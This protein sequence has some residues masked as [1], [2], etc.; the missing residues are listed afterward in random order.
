MNG[1]FAPARAPRRFAVGLLR[2]LGELIVMPVVVGMASVLVAVGLFPLFGTAGGAVKRFDERLLSHEKTKITLPPLPERSTIY[3]ADGTRLATL[4]LDENREIVSLKQVNDV[5]Q[6][7]VLAIEDHKFFEHGPVDISSILR[8]AIAN[9]KAGHIVQGG[10]TISQQLIKNTETGNAETFQRKF[11]EAQDAILLEKEY[12]KAQILELYLNTIYFGHRVYGIGTAA[13]YYF[14]RSASRLTAAQAALLGGMI[15]SPVTFD[16]IEHPDTALIRRNQ[17]LSAMVKYGWLEPAEYAQAVA[18][19]IKL[20]AKGRIANTVGREPYWISYVVD[21]FEHNPAFGKT[22]AERRR[23][24]FQGGLKITTTLSPKLQNVARSV[25]KHHLPESGPQPPAD[26][27]AA[28]VS[29]QAKTGAIQTMVGGTDYSKQKI[30]LAS[31]GARSTG[32]AFKA[33]TLVA[34]MEQGVPPGR[35]YSA[36]SP[37]TIPQCPNNGG[38]WMPFNAEGAG[39]L[40]YLNLWE[41]TADSINVVFAQLIADIGPDSVVKAAKAMGLTG[42]IPDVC[43]IT[44]G[45]VAVSP[46][47]MTTAYSTLANGGKHCTAYGVQR[48]LASD[49]STIYDHKPQCKQV[50]SAKVAAQVT[51]M[52]EGVI[53]HG[54]GTAAQIGRPEAGKTGTGQDF[55]DAWFM[56]YVPQTCTGVWVG[57]SKGEIPMRSLRVLGGGEAFGGTIAAPM[58]HDYMVQAVANLP[59]QDFRTPPPQKPGTVPDVVGMKEKDAQDTL[60]KANFVPISVTV[61]S[62]KPA[63]TVVSQSPAGGSSAILGSPVTIN[64]SNGKGPKPTPKPTSVVVPD[65]IGETRHQASDD[66]QSQGFAVAVTYQTVKDPKK[67]GVVLE[68]APSPGTKAPRGSTVTI[69]V[70]RTGP[71]R[72]PSPSGDLLR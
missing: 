66:L 47:S 40:G 37:A 12:T 67:N 23:L 45:A 46:L 32:S 41:A 28:I 9:L 30:D 26:P 55:Q 21:E 14:N 59:V 10:S 54:T 62:F 50:V 63:G 19:P 51:A 8:A 29:I 64:V 61:D 3:A 57:Y 48:V 11:Q 17:V 65:V 39:D 6:H 22:V 16:P 18:T 34:A 13:Q 38:P 7:A 44:L 1:S 27:Q 25:M 72:L 31:Q 35:V 36:R 5:A 43:A 53:S 4:F 71:G 15:A 42:Y 70:G 52:L 69:V 49:G 2:R 33:F 24:L 20:S 68:Q 58:W 56:G 60:R